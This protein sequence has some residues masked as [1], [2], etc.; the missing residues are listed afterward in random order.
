MKKLFL[1]LV[2]LFALGFAFTACD[3][4]GESSG[5]F[6]V[7]TRD[8]TFLQ[9]QDVPTEYGER[10]LITGGDYESFFEYTYTFKG[11]E[12][13]GVLDCGIYES[14]SDLKWKIA[15]GSKS[16]GV[17]CYQ[18]DKGY[19]GAYMTFSFKYDQSTKKVTILTLE[20][21]PWGKSYSDVTNCLEVFK[22]LVFTLGT[23]DDYFT[24]RKNVIRKD[25]GKA[26]I[27]KVTG[28]EEK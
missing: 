13:Y 15:F 19:R 1:G 2:I 14:G 8:T 9:S 28:E 5:S 21:A 22:G 11:V 26:K 17:I 20:K 6:N 4:G 16:E 25:S 12:N 23:Y 27:G 18:N 7:L 3:G 24:D 10:Y